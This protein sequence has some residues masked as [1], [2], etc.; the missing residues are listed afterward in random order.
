MTDFEK[1]TDFGNLY[2]AYKKAKSG[3]GYKKSSAKFEVKALEG[4]HILKEQL[5][6]KQ[7]KVSAYNQFYVYEPKQRLIE[8]AAFKDKVVQHSLCDNVLLPK[9]QNVFIRNNFAGQIGKGTLFGIVE[10]VLDA[11]KRIKTDNSISNPPYNISWEPP[12]A[13]EALTDERFNKCEMPPK[14]NMFKI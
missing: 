7:Y 14:R 9:L 6:S 3:K 13:L 4:I 1:V 11:E 8:A 12:T 10:K 2:K 5:E